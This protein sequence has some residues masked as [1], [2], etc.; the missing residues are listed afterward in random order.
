MNWDPRRNHF[1]LARL[2]ARLMRKRAPAPAERVIYA[3][4][5]HQSAVENYAVAAW[6]LLSM[7]C[8]I[9]AALPLVAPAALLAALPLAMI[10][11]QIPICLTG[12]PLSNQSL[13]AFALMLCGA[14]A[15]AY[16]ALQPG[17]VRFVAWFFL[18][19]IALNA[20]AWVIVRL[21]EE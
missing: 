15:A 10:A 12:I 19:V 9:A 20:I 7:T 13:N 18:G 6:F 8:F 11:V 3:A 16:F 21:C 5:R 1:A 14:A 17:W 2:V 4:D